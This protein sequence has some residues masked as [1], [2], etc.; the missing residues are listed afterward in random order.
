MIKHIVLWSLEAETTLGC[1]KK[2]MQERIKT[3]L[4]S[5]PGLIEGLLDLKVHSNTLAYENNFDIVLEALFQD[6]KALEAYQK[7]P[8]HQKFV[9]YIRKATRARSALDYEY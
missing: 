3:D 6:A 7:H 8:E 1:S 5:L 9:Q 4:E 2:T